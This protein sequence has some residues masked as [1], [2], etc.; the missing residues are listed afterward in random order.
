MEA[1]MFQRL[2][3]SESALRRHRDAPFAAERERYLQHCADRGATHATLLHKSSELLWIACQLDTN[4]PLGVGIE[5]LDQIVRRRTSLCKGRTTAERLIN[6]ARPWLR[7]LGW[8]RGH[9]VEV[10]YRELLDRYVAWMRNERGLTASTVVQ[11]QCR[12]KI[13]LQWWATTD[14]PLSDLGPADID[15]YFVSEGAQRW[16][17]VSASSVATALRAFVRY[18]A[19]Q[20]T[21]DLRLAGTIRGPRIYEQESL[22]FA[23]SWLDVQRILADSP[24]DLRRDVRDR[25]IL[26]LL[27]I[28]GMRSGEVASLR[29]DQLDWRHRLIRLFRLK[30]RQPQTYPLVPSVAE[31]L[32]RY[33]DTVRPRTPHQ[34]VFIGLQSPQRPLTTSCIYDIV[35]RRFLALG[36]QVAHRGPHALRHA[37]A[38]R[39]VADG[40]TLKEIGDHLGHRST[41]AT[42]TYAKVDLIALREVGDFDLGELS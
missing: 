36:I 38:A 11:W 29:L 28:Y 42:R 10:P 8:W 22:P 9:A 39:L 37:C 18:A 3:R 16:C 35:S 12:A 27:A 30:R 25:A 4:A 2:L 6:I 33:I 1:A 17:R 21:C 13:F 23:P 34:Q 7:Y 20:G 24:T 41:S 32:A 19:S 5:Q 31:A 26:M 15:R 40:L 14:R